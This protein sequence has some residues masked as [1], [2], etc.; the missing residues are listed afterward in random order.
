MER[1]YSASGTVTY[2]GEPVDHGDIV[3]SPIDAAKGRAASAIID[4]GSFALTTVSD[5]DGAL[6]GQYRVTVTSKDVDLSAIKPAPGRSAVNPAIIGKAMRD[7]KN[8]VPKKYASSQTSPLTAEVKEQSNSF[9]F[10]L[11]D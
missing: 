11:A 4:K 3:F 1:R 10:D 7:A 5:R 9:T 6:P 2:K 8:L